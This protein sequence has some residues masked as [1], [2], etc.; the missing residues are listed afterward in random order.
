[1]PS[2]FSGIKNFL[3]FSRGERNGIIILI[4]LVLL[5][6][7]SP[8]FY[9]TFYRAIPSYNSDFYAKADSFFSSLSPIPEETVKFRENPIESE[10]IE[11]S[12]IRKYFLFDPNT[13]TVEELVQLGLS[14]KQAN[15]IEKYRSKGGLF[16]TPEQFS[17]VYVIDSSTFLK[18]KPWIKINR[19]TLN[20][21][22]KVKRDSFPKVEK[23]AAIVELNST[24]TLELVKIKGIGKSFA[25]RIIAYRNLL[26]GYVN[27]HQLKEVYGIKPELIN[28]IE[29]SVTI[30]S[31]R[32]K[33]INLNLVSYEE[34]K[35][36]PYL[37]DYQSRAIIFYRSKVGS[38]KSTQELIRNKI[39][40]NDTYESIKSYLTIY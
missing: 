17:K 27:I 20:S 40:P 6:M 29:S 18:L 9:R 2:I 26:G 36:H 19:L 1:M 8:I 10:E 34:L 30:D 16:Q 35:K 24:D 31:T 3:T 39:L 13:V 22:P 12:R 32:I 11:T 4:L 38:F 37:S 21:H 33:L 25:R 7:F 14:V 5:L 28:T 15:V 23:V